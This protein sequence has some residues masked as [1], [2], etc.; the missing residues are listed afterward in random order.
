[1][2]VMAPPFDDDLREP[3]AL[4]PSDLQCV[5]R[6]L[7][8]EAVARAADLAEQMELDGVDALFAWL[9]GRRAAGAAA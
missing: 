1:M 5:A 4:E 7:R 8:A 2:G 3:R 9:R 6:T